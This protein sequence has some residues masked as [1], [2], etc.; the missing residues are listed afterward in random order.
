VVSTLRSYPTLGP[1]SAGM[2]DCL[3]AGV[4]ANNVSSDLH[5]FWMTKLSTGLICLVKAEMS[6]FWWQVTLDHR[7]SLT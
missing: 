3:W 2:G 4:P 7:L 1:V 5:P 6:P